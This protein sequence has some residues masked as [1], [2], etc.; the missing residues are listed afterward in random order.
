MATYSLVPSPCFSAAAVCVLAAASPAPAHDAAA[1]S[2]S[3]APTA[4]VGASTPANPVD[5]GGERKTM[6]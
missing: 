5:A 3:D 2:S 4:L 6:I 1:P